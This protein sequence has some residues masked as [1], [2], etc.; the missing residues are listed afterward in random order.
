MSLTCDDSEERALAMAMVI[1]AANT[2]GIY[3][4]Q[5]FRQDDKPKYRRGFSINLGVLAVGLALAILRKVDQLR[6]RRRQRTA[7][8][9]S[10]S[11]GPHDSLS[12]DEASDKA[13]PES[14]Q[15]AVQQTWAAPEK[16]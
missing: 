7:S 11:G 2:A 12:N 4:A 16:H 14:T 8:T 1:M 6:Q 3:G 5:I 10:S 15:V 13:G 9:G